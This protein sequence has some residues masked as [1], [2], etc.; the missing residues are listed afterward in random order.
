M[1]DSHPAS[2]PR[3][4]HFLYVMAATGEKPGRDAELQ[5]YTLSDNYELAAKGIFGTREDADAELKQFLVGYRN[6][7]AE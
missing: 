7:S 6:E 3:I 4:A 1:L 5:M 2:G